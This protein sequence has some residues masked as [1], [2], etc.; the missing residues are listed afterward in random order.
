M[1]FFSYEMTKEV[2]QTAV[3]NTTPPTFGGVTSA[4]A[5]SDGSITASWSAATGSAATPIR[6]KVYAALGASVSPTSL[7]VA[8]NLVEEA[9]STWTMARFYQLGDQATFFNPGSTYTV[10][11][12]AFSAEN[13]TETNTVTTN[14]TVTSINYNTLP[15]TIWDQLQ[16]AHTVTGSFGKAIQGSIEGDLTVQRANNLD[17][18][19]TSVSSRLAA[20][21]YV[22]PDNADI[23]TIVATTN[24]FQFDGSNNVKA[25]A[26]VVSDKTGYSLTP[27][28]EAAISVAVWAALQS[29]NTTSGSFG[30]ALQGVITAVRANNLDNLDTTVSSRATQTSVDTAVSQTTAS[31]LAA[32]IW[33]AAVAS[34][35]MAGSFGAQLQNSSSTPASIATAVWAALQA[36]N[37]VSGSF[38]AALQGS[39]DVAVSSRQSAATALSQYNT[40]LSDIGAIP[41]DPLLTTDSRLD[42]LDA[43]ISATQTAS[44]ALT[45]YNTIVAGLVSIEGDIAAIPT[46]PVLTTDSRLDYLDAHISATQTAAT[47][48]T[49]Y[50]TLVSDI[51]AI[52]TNPVLTT[53]SR[54]SNL[55][56]T[57]SSRATQT[58]VNNVQN[59]V[60]T[61]L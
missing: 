39:V 27:S 36:S 17:N 1:G 19:D 58:S 59:L 34:Y 55:D 10:G 37:T 23:A 18:L 25:N 6:Y 31:A 22:A 43:H 41:T 40:L 48:L 61:T 52:P 32:A 35:N 7:F 51:D 2:P 54:L 46:N 56:A 21:S 9:P 4:V 28:E 3:Q 26:E 12:R 29:A 49:Q 38:G 8:A 24:K 11:V 44:T 33:N 45:Q 50:D 16:S 13:I 47:A 5:N 53:D 20:S 30:A 14:V 42:Y 60:I 57:V 15:G